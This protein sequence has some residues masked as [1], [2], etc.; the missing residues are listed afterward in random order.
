MCHKELIYNIGG[1]K[2]NTEGT[3]HVV[4]WLFSRGLLAYWLLFFRIWGKAV[5]DSSKYEYLGT[6]EHLVCSACTPALLDGGIGSKGTAS[7]NTLLV[8]D[9]IIV[10]IVASST[11]LLLR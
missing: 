7:C 6:G 10:A 5:A 3:F 11:L 2:S 4:Y 1:T 9:F 8:G